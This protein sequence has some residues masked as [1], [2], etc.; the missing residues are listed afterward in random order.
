MCPALGQIISLVSTPFLVPT[1]DYI[2]VMNIVWFIPAAIAMLICIW[3]VNVLKQFSEVN[4]IIYIYLYIYMYIYIYT[5]L[6][7]D[8][9][10]NQITH[11]LLQA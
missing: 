2:P 11:R 10:L 7:N 4:L 9:R 5:F 1:P 6:I 3:K 8:F